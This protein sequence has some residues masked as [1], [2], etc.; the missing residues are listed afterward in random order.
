MLV[1]SRKSNEQIVIDNNI[2]IKVLA[3]RG[4]TVRLGIDAPESVGVVRGEIVDRVDES[5]P[6][7]MRL[8]SA[9]AERFIADETATR[10]SLRV[11]G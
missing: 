1:L 7:R 3:I 5:L 6:C 10:T 9:K 4:N 8:D 2:S 11:T